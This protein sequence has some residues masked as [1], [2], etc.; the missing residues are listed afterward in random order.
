MIELSVVIAGKTYQ[1]DSQTPKS[2]AIPVQFN[3]EQPNFFGASRAQA[4]PLR[5]N[6]F[7]G[8]T[9]RGGSCN[10][11]EIRMVPHCNGTHTETVGHIVHAQHA[12][13]ESI[14]Q[15]VMP[16]VVVSVTP[17][18]ASATNDTYR[19]APEPGDM[20]ITLDALE[21][22]LAGYKHDELT[23]LV[24]RTLPNHATKK[25]TEYGDQCQPPYFSADATRYLVERGVQH[26][27]VDIPS[28]DKMHDAGWLT[29]HHIFWNVPQGTHEATPDTWAGKT[30]TEM[31]FV[32]DEIGDGLYL[33][34]LQMP[35]FCSDAAPSRPVVYAL[36]QR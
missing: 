27:L 5:G 12:V 14:A 10:V 29:N 6:G 21:L 35:A 22:K 15:S 13:L 1:V 18:A 31:I 20:L 25:A 26:L 17:V 9:R 16:S 32:D 4:G 36:S 28:I 3:G 7:I 34:N 33:L 11:T 30:V 8:D 23:A 24:V 2:L 19:P